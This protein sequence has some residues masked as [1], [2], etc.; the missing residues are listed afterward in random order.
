MKIVV[1]AMSGDNAPKAIIE[2]AALARKQLKHELILTG[3][4]EEI[5]GYLKEYGA[6]PDDPGFEIVNTTEII[7]MEE[8]PIQIKNKK[9]SSMRRA[10][11]L[12]AEGRADAC[13][14]AGNTGALYM[15]AV[16]FV[17][18]IKGVR[19]AAIASVLPLS[20]P[21]L[22]LDS[23][24]NVSVASGDLEAFAL[25]GSV[26]AESVLGIKRP[27]IGLLNNG[28]E[29]TKG[30]QVL[31]DACER[32]SKRSD[33]RFVG[34]VEA[35]AL[36]FN[37]CDV[38]VTDGFSG[39]VVLKLTEGLGAFFMKKLGSVYKKNVV[40]LA[41][42]ALVKKE[43]SSMKKEFDAS[44]HG[45]APLL[46]IKKPVIKA[47]G[48]SDARAVMNAIRVAAVYAETGV[49]AEIEKTLFLQQNDTNGGTNVK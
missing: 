28:T 11:E 20:S 6:D 34:N 27:K 22:L 8:D 44:E 38:L 47:H 40:T 32:L 35:K 33:I 2:G 25:M 16:L 5:K 29:Q 7:T 31:R 48:S 43:L 39:N 23:G 21:L 15:G 14:S 36:P 9:D 37:A 41:S 45:G 1:D 12:L 17:S 19:K 10:L 18:R 49:T 13:V 24:A 26:Y 46:G 30:T 42:A 4:A 3:D